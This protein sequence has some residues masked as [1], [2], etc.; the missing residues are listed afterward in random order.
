MDR[1]GASGD[2]SRSERRCQRA[3]EI[4]QTLA[5]FQARFSEAHVHFAYHAAFPVALTPHL[6]YCLWANFQTDTEHQNLQVPWIAV[7]DVLLSSLCQ[8]VGHE[9]YEMSVEVRNYL[10]DQ[11]VAHPRFGQKR[12]EALAHFL[13][14]Y[15]QHELNQAKPSI[16]NLAQSQRWTALAHV[17]PEEVAHDL[18]AT[19]SQLKLNDKTEWL[20]MAALAETIAKPLQQA[21]F[22]SLLTYLQ[23]M[24]E[25]VRG[26][27]SQAESTLQSLPTSNSRMVTAGVI[28][29]VPEFQEAGWTMEPIVSQAPVLQSLNVETA[30]LIRQPRW[31]NLGTRWEV[32]RWEQQTQLFYEKLENQITLEMVVIPQ[33]HYLR[34]S[35]RQEGDYRERP[36]HAVSIAS[37]FLSRFPITQAQWRAVAQTQ[38]VRLELNPDPSQ[39]KGDHLP[40]EHITWFE[41]I[42]FCE[43]LQLQTGKP[44]RLPSEAEW[45]YAC[46]AGTT[47]PFHFGATLSP[48]LASYDS[49]QRYRSSPGGRSRQQTFKVG[50]RRAANAFGLEEMH[51]NVWEWC[52]DH[53]YDDYSN[54]PNDGS[55]RMTDQRFSP[56]VIRGGSWESEP[57]ICRSA[58]RNGV[59]P[60]NRVLT[61]GFR[62]AV[63]RLV[64]GK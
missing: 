22:E 45:E 9:L 59:P 36:Q 33:G 15:V 35:D 32:E 53:W 19:V 60:E 30:K 6:T 10:L 21:Y 40:V 38:K 20:R 24:R 26:D 47:T 28:L 25:L 34:G 17:Y 52:A 2:D 14:S 7:A 64:N 18:A 5:A 8:E 4:A 58:Y 55:V 31:L 11:M 41:A 42:E 54:A 29:P 57:K 46:R 50:F 16:R 12:V 63:S 43:R 62:V 51:G 37:F 27:Q 1:A 48:Q 44:Y 61:I 13:L 23:G 39:F 49:S 3:E 56:R